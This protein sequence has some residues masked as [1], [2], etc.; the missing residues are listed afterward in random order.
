MECFPY[1][2]PYPPVNQHPY[3]ERE[4]ETERER[5]A[6]RDRDREIEAV[7]RVQPEIRRTGAAAVE[8]QSRDSRGLKP[9]RAFSVVVG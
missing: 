6:V 1:A 9:R 5:K 3:T 8:S 4:R 7:R 2:K